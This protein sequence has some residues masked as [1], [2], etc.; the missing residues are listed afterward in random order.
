MKG[1]S[2]NADL[3]FRGFYCLS[4]LFLKHGREEEETG[5]RE[6]ITKKRVDRS[7]TKL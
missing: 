4:S 2:S 7:K 1:L 5:G 6:H 3:A